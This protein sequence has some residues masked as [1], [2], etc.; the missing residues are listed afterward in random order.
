LSYVIAGLG[1][2]WGVDGDSAVGDQHGDLTSG[3]KYVNVYFYPPLTSALADHGTGSLNYVWEGKPVQIGPAVKIARIP[4]GAHTAL[5][6]ASCIRENDNTGIT[7]LAVSMI[8]HHFHADVDSADPTKVMVI[9]RTRLNPYSM[10]NSSFSEV[11][12]T[13][14][15]LEKLYPELKQ[16]S[17]N[18]S[19]GF[20]L[21]DV[22]DDNLLTAE[23]LRDLLNTLDGITATVN[24][25]GQV[26]ITSDSNAPGSAIR[27]V[28]A[29]AALGLPA[30]T[31]YG[32]LT[33][34]EAVDQDGVPLTFTGVLPGDVLELDQE[35]TVVE[36][37]DQYLTV[38]PG[39]PSN[40]SRAQFNIFSSAYR[41]Y[42]ATTTDLQSFLTDRNYLVNESL[43]KLD[44]V[45][46]PIF[47]SGKGLAS[48]GARA[49]AMLK[50]LLCI[51]V[52][53]AGRTPEHGVTIPPGTT[54]EGILAAYEAPEIPAVTQAIQGVS[55]AGY[56][57]AADLMSDGDM[58]GLYNTDQETASYGGAVM[59]TLRDSAKDL[60][61]RPVRTNDV[62]D[63]SNTSSSSVER[64]TDDDVLENDQ[65]W[66][67]ED[68][69][70]T[71]R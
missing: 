66:G 60:P 42:K 11:D 38:T 39:I 33:Q 5:D 51:L 2:L 30:G 47:A 29:P 44:A 41:S 18:V 22:R 27:I 62:A 67:V 53:T 45:M 13:K 49:K 8:G 71:E 46:S 1:T 69:R 20:Y 68:D 26:V 4:A 64:A 50:D 28:S 54:L 25:A 14:T 65:L 37:F 6:L 52:A 31:T 12:T 48:S 34:F 9:P 56:D 35:Y 55:Q 32:V 57:R 43:D 21:G 36:N 40:T 17:A 3:G 24:D 59:S 23:E 7:A 70:F 10:V 61:D 19:L 58:T 15:E 16:N 63:R